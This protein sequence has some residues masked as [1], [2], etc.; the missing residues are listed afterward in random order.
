MIKYPTKNIL[1]KNYTVF[2]FL[3][4]KVNSDWELYQFVPVHPNYYTDTAYRQPV[5]EL[6][7]FV[8]FW[9]NKFSDPG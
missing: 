1:W 2:N 7:K 6:Y 9:E 4:I 8:K 5:S 3:Q